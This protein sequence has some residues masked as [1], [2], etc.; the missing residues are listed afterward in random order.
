M[1]ILPVRVTDVGTYPPAMRQGRELVAWTAVFAAVTLFSRL[2]VD[3]ELNLSTLFLVG[4]IAAGAIIIR[5]PG[6]WW[7]VLVPAA[8]TRLAL[9]PTDLYSAGQLASRTA[10]LFTVVCAYAV[11]I[12][13]RMRPV[14]RPTATVAGD[15]TWFLGAAVLTAAVRVVLIYGLDLVA[16]VPVQSPEIT[17]A[18]QTGMATVVGFIT[19]STIF[20]ALTG[21]RH[22]LAAYRRAGTILLTV[23]LALVLVSA[24]L[25]VLGQWYPAIAYSVP[26]LLLLAALT[27][28]RFLTALL[29]GA[30]VIVMAVSLAR[31]LGAYPT[32]GDAGE[33]LTGQI[34]M[35]VLAVSIYIV[36]A[37]ATETRVS[38]SVRA[39][40]FAQ[41]P[42]ASAIVRRLQGQS[43]TVVDANAAFE[44]LVNLPPGGAT[45]RTLADLIDLR[46][47]APLAGERQVSFTTGDGA[48]R[49]LML[50]DSTPLVDPSGLPAGADPDAT[51]TLVM[52]EDVTAARTS[53]E[54]LRLQA[55]RDTLTGLPNRVAL[56]E[57]LDEALDT[58]TTPSHVALC[59]IDI[60]DLQHVNDTLGHTA[61]DQV[62]IEVGRRLTAA[63]EP[64][65]VVLRVGGDE[66]AVLCPAATGTGTHQAP[67]SLT[68]V[69]GEHVQAVSG[70]DLTVSLTGGLAYADAAI[71][72]SELIRRA[73][74]ALSR[75][76]RDSRANLVVFHEGDDQPILE[77]DA[78]E[79]RLR[80]ALD[81][82]GLCVYFQAIV[83]NANG[84]AVGAEALVRLPAE[85]GTV[86]NPAIFLPLAAELGLMGV[87]TDQ[88]LDAACDAAAAWRDAGTPVVVG[89]NAPPDWLSESAVGRVR[90][91]AAAR[92][93]DPGLLVIEVT[94]EQA[95]AA[96]PDAI[97]VLVRLR[98][99]GFKVALDDFGTGY[100][101]LD[102]FRSLPSNAVKIAMPFVTD[103]LR[104]A[105]DR[106]L[107]GSMIALIHRFGRRCVAE[108]VE[109]A[110][111]YEA[112][113]E[114][115]CDLIQG[116]Y[117]SRPVPFDEFPTGLI[118]V[119][120]DLVQVP[121]SL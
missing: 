91:A 73:D 72:P 64:G 45:G 38:Q 71:R 56:V 44:A 53:E 4:G 39:A 55:R 26:P 25:T 14:A 48:R 12:R 49:W 47:E 68:R 11:I 20:L 13:W 67:G 112:L 114:L 6:R 88:V 63:A 21:W 87:L 96:G 76:K 7:L 52:F 51:L 16:A 35:A 61:G 102:V 121:A 120:R 86:T 90:A 50:T 5:P 3:P 97:D 92:N 23:A 100:A 70:R 30:A 36:S 32:A 106:D 24:Y 75:A 79:Q 77:R 113:R 118:V 54:L 103:M 85:D 2:L 28:H 65:D 111:Q 117:V 81:T 19:G 59:I 110:A 116:Y 8:V 15:V 89:F 107:V 104:S 105:Q 66:F 41:S 95:L 94:E 109:T 78:L 98:D 83:S 60:D 115:G 93:L 1:D 99:A 58:V 37:F 42:I 108:G 40:T 10:I 74:I 69:L 82:R 62:L 18:A 27:Q 84:C 29:T 31:G 101:G 22:A 34:Y 80:H 17:Y 119:Q 9:A 43:P 57:R 46:P 33:I